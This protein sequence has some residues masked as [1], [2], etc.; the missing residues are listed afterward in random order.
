LW[1]QLPKAGGW[2]HTMTLPF[3]KESVLVT[4]SSFMM[5]MNP[6]AKSCCPVMLGAVETKRTE[7]LWAGA[8]L[9]D[10]GNDLPVVRKHFSWVSAAWS[11]PCIGIPG[12]VEHR[13]VFFLPVQPP[14]ACAAHPLPLLETSVA[15]VGSGS[16]HPLVRV[17]WGSSCLRLTLQLM[18]WN[19]KATRCAWCGNSH[20]CEEC[21]T[22]RL[23]WFC[24]KCQGQVKNQR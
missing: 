2:V 16:S 4:Q 17:Q 7:E 14:S 19:R 5:N 21:W 23:L 9:N 12:V 22:N 15:T 24:S 3:A 10:V 1:K 6:A 18:G 8:E 20:G 11:A 13:A